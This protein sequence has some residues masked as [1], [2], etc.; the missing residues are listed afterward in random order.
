MYICHMTLLHCCCYLEAV[1]SVSTFIDVIIVTWKA[2]LVVGYWNTSLIHLL[3]LYFFIGSLLPPY[4]W[5]HKTKMN[6]KCSSCTLTSHT[7]HKIFSCSTYN[8]INWTLNSQKWRKCSRI[9][10]SSAHFCHHHFL[11]HSSKQC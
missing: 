9:T 2:I 8:S 7:F 3:T 1:I 6:K 11:V 10:I 5:I 4:T